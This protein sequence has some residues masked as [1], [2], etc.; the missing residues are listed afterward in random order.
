MKLSLL[1]VPAAIAGAFLLGRA[2]GPGAASAAP[3]THAYTLH[4]GD[5]A[6]APAPAMT[7]SAEAEAGKPNLLCQ[8]PTKARHAV[9][10]YRDL[11]LV[12][13]GPDKV[14]WSGKP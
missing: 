4:R 9:V 3:A 8:R 5:S 13:Q 12:F 11:I 1:L 10:F 6:R 7:C 2:T 14:V